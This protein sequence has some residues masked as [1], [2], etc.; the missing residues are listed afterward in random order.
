[1][2]LDR[3]AAAAGAGMVVVALTRKRLMVQ[4]SWRR[5]DGGLGG[6]RW[7]VRGRTTRWNPVSEVMAF[8]LRRPKVEVIFLVRWMVLVEKRWGR[9]R[10]E[11]RMWGVTCAKIRRQG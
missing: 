7:Q 10:G 3:G 11:D 5:A 8:S 6:M 4:D 2:V 9:F 1:M